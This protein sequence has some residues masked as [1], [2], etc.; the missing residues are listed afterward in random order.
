MIKFI[1]YLTLFYIVFKFLFGNIFK[2]K[3][4]QFNQNQNKDTQTQNN[5]EDLHIKSSSN[6][7]SSNKDKSIGEYVDFEEIKE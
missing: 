5:D 1:L 4:Y 2:I 6:N 7:K 3:V